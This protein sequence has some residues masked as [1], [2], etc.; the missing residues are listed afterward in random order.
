MRSFLASLLALLVFHQALTAQAPQT[1]D[2]A[3][4]AK[5]LGIGTKV[6]LQ[7]IGGSHIRGRISAVQP[8]ALTIYDGRATAG[9]TRTIAFTN[10]VTL[11][12]QPATHTPVLA[13]AAAGAIV[14]VVVIALSVLLIERRN[15]GGL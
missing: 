6:E 3:E 13:W 5:A 8:D 10:I 9:K 7:L 1:T 12:R 4:T 11:K 14:A 2:L 15:E